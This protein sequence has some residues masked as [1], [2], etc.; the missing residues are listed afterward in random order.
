MVIHFLIALRIDSFSL[1]FFQ[2][3]RTIVQKSLR[4]VERLKGTS[5]AF[6]AI[7]S[8]NLQFPPTEA[9]RIMLD[10][11][12]TF[13]QENPTSNLKDIRFV[14]L[15]RDKMVIDAFSQ[16][17][18]NLQNNLSGWNL[19]QIGEEIGYENVNIVQGDLTNEFQSEAI[20]NV[21]GSDGNIT[22]AGSLSET[23]FR[24]AGSYIEHE[25]R[26]L[27]DRSVKPKALMT[28]GGNLSASHII[29][30]IPSSSNK[31][32]IKKSLEKGLLLAKKKYI[33]S[34]SLPAVGT[35]GHGISPS[36]SA[37]LIFQSLKSVWG[38]RANFPRVR[39]VLLQSPEFI[40][41]FELEQVTP[42]HHKGSIHK[43]KMGRINIE[44][45]EGDLTSEKTHAIV[46]IVNADMDMENAGELS[47]GIA[48]V[49][50]HKVKEECREMGPQPGGTAVM[51]KG[52]DLNTRHIIHLIPGS[53]DVNHLQMCL[54][55]CLRLADS[56]KLHSIHS[57]Q[58]E[59]VDMVCRLSSLQR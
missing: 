4:N 39:I 37:Q 30:I 41:A 59:Q 36:D 40:H 32:E 16:E 21:V 56:K 19:P 25:F 11:T 26:Q 52:G 35:G 50:G 46:N 42:Q 6:P 13:C 48:Q 53:S 27:Y 54:E 24:T 17:M 43:T 33:P 34:I 44:V 3:L 1:D 29:H 7:G 12:V 38:N 57:Q 20:F 23:V 55:K 5:V 14:L 8:G 28:S 15:G 45:E 47:K 10:E 18:V 2:C 51:T 22:R 49:C 58:L 9:A 31:K